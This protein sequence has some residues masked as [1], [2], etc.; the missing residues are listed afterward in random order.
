MAKYKPQLPSVN[1]AIKNLKNK[2]LPVYYFFGEDDFSIEKA[3]KAV[4]KAVAPFIVSDFD[5]EIFYGEKGS[6]SEALDFAAAF[7]FGS[8]KKL[9]IFKDADKI[10]DKKALGSYAK[11]PADFTVIIFLHK[12][13]V[14][15]FKTEPFS[16]LLENNY[17]Y[18]AKE[19]KGQN[20]LAWLVSY[21]ED[22]G[23][24]LSRENAQL[25]VDITGENRNLL[26]DQLEKIFIFMGDEK[27]ISFDAVKSL[28]TQLKEFTI[29]DLQNAVGRK[30]KSTALKV[31]FNLLEKGSEP[32]FIVAMLTRY[33]TGLTKV[34]ELTDLNL[35]DQQAA[36]IV[37]THPFYYKDYKYARKLF[38]DKDI[39]NAS[40]ALLKADINIKSTSIDDK[41][42]V[43]ILIAEIL[44]R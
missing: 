6:V 15:A 11:S 23:K 43:T 13:A 32:V 14:T 19:L 42:L 36:G 7:P 10:K 34:S 39:I 35:T 12:G 37:G 2:I 21:A 5:R 31:A 20:L 26:E 38:S 33:F 16:T 24:N 30:D 8:E 28:S 1:D 3:Y 44:S 22:N 9:I 29:F 4:E 40:R 25:L 41:S 18:E 17:L 27:V